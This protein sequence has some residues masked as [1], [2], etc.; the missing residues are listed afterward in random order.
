[1]AFIDFVVIDECHRSI[2]NFW[3]QLP[4]YFDPFQTGLTTS[5]ANR[6]F[7]YF[8][9]NLDCDYGYPKAVAALRQ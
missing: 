1:M 5:P 4:D 6:T 3:R 9:K 2:Y 7:G 8:R